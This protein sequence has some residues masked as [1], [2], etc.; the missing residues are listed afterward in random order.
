MHLQWHKGEMIMVDG[1]SNSSNS[2]GVYGQY[3]DYSELK[4]QTK[5]EGNTVIVTQKG[6]DGQSFSVST[7]KLEAPTLSDYHADLASMGSFGATFGA[8]VLALIQEATSDIV[9]D[10]RAIIY[11]THTQSAHLMEKQADKMRDQA[12]V[13]LVMGVVSGALQIAGGLFGAAKTSKALGSGLSDAS[14]GLKNTQISAQ[15]QIF[16]AVGGMVD[17]GAKA[18]QTF[19]EADIKRLEADQKR[20]DAFADQIKS[21]TDSL[22]QTVNKALD[23]MSTISQNMI[24]A[25]KRILG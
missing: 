25:N 7:P 9:S 23:T 14:L 8:A 24:D 19:L 21:I 18:G 13:T 16:N 17:S 20:I 15:Q 3:G 22:N 4:T 1:V 5:T 11:V 6:E 2:M 12:I 10:S